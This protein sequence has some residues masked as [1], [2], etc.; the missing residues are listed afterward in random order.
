MGVLQISGS[1]NSAELCGQRNP[2]SMESPAGAGALDPEIAFS[3]I[4]VAGAY[5]LADPSP[6]TSASIGM[7]KR[8]CTIGNIAPTVSMN[9]A[10]LVCTLTGTA[11]ICSW[12]E[13]MWNGSDWIVIGQSAVTY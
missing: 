1:D 11:A 3:R 5:T 6:A 7:I 4:S 2:S 10:A 8:I 9:A 12:L 13:V